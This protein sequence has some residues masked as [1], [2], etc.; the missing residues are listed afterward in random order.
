MRSIGADETAV[1]VK[2][3][4]TVV[5]VVTDTE[6]GEILGLEALVERDADGFME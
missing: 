2:G 6:T 5:G 4:K 1:R 3:V